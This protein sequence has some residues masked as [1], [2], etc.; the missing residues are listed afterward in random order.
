MLKSINGLCDFHTKTLK[1]I[2]L[3]S[4]SALLL[5]SPYSCS[6]LQKQRK[7]KKIET[8]LEVPVFSQHH[9]GFLVIDPDTNDTIYS[10]S[11]NRYFIPAS[12]VKIATLFASLKLIPDSIPTIKYIAVEDTLYFEGL[13][14]PTTLHPY[15]RDSTLFKFLDQYSELI[16]NLNNYTEEPWPP[17]WA[18]EDFD[19]SFA[20]ER[21]SLPL[22]GNTVFLSSE[23][24]PMVTPGYFQDSIST[25]DA[26]FQR[27]RNQNL[28]FYPKG[29][30][31]TLEIP[32]RLDDTLIR[33]LLVHSLDK[34]IQ[35]TNRI[36]EGVKKTLYS[37]SRD[38]VL[39][40][41]MVESDN[42]LAEQLLIAASSAISDTL[43]S[44]SAINH[45]L[46]NELGNLKNQ[47]RW[48]DGSGL[49][50][51]NLF[52]PSY[53]VAI[54]QRLYMEYGKERTLSFFPVG[55][56]SGTIKDNFMGTPE[57]YIFAKSG[58]MGNIYCLSGYLQ[59]RSGKVLIFSF[60]NNNFN[61]RTDLIRSEMEAILRYIRESY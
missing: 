18:W 41:M 61:R 54:L 42:F 52:T 7:S 47:P 4:T 46:A 3:I 8:A 10:K 13:G 23:S 51:Y 20:V 35:L 43:S 27:T 14:N 60:M 33:D 50:R 15:F 22:Y 37:G 56:I 53:L 6:S 49:S 58:S 5:W 32:F 36:P 39:K 55:G 57:P 11:A 24:D 40:H 16:L 21:S 30:K 25:K 59:T 17:G 9:S 45:I 48:V 19:Q 2:L 44:K 12:N 26:L 34:K 1:N 38:S 28:F 31:D 29:L